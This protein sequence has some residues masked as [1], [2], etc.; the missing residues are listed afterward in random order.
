MHLIV[1]ANLYYTDPLYFDT[2]GSTV[3]CNHAETCPIHLGCHLGTPNVFYLWIFTITTWHLDS[4]LDILNM[5]W[6]TSIGSRNSKN[7]NSQTVSPMDYVVTQSQKSQLWSNR[8][9][10]SYMVPAWGRNG[11]LVGED[12]RGVIEKKM[13]IRLRF[14]VGHPYYRVTNILAGV[15]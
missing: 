4:E 5:V 3:A 8:V 15:K 6:T 12:G 9:M 14:E 13:R 1:I 2:V 7:M 10:F 11:G